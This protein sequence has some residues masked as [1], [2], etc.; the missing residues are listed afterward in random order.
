MSG[1]GTLCGI[2]LDEVQVTTFEFSP[3]P[4]A[5]PICLLRLGG[6]D[7]EPLVSFTP[8]AESPDAALAKDRDRVGDFSVLFEDE[9]A[10]DRQDLVERS[11]GIIRAFPDVKRAI[12]EDRELIY[13]WGRFVDLR[14]LRDRITSFVARPVRGT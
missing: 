5:C 7:E 14:A 1:E 10:H 6:S 3:R 13:V 9:A 12:H 11:V 2:P 8:R 4:E